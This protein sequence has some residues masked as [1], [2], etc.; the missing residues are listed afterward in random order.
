MCPWTTVWRN[1]LIIFSAYPRWVG[2]YLRLY[3]FCI[4]LHTDLRLSALVSASTCFTEEEIGITC[5][6]YCSDTIGNVVVHRLLSLYGAMLHIIFRLSH[7]IVLRSFTLKCCKVVCTDNEGK[8]TLLT[9]PCLYLSA[10]GF[11]FLINPAFYLK[12]IKKERYI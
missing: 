12:T 10:C 5:N 3:L 11:T 7:E 2:K 4:R 8:L 9:L 6:K 1:Y